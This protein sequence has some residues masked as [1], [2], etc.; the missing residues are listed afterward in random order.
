MR[1]CVFCRKSILKGK[2]SF[3]IPIYTTGENLR[4]W[5]RSA[6]ISD[7]EHFSKSYRVC[8]SHFDIKYLSTTTELRLRLLPG[9]IP[10]INLRSSG[11]STQISRVPGK[12]LFFGCFVPYS[13]LVQFQCQSVLHHIFVYIFHIYKLFQKVSILKVYFS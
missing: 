3:R 1:K 4:I 11:V 12:I 7:D 5:K 9:A 13:M 6:G 2:P 8:T 10:T